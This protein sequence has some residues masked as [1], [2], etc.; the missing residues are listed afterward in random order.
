[1]EAFKRDWFVCQGIG[2]MSEAHFIWEEHRCASVAPFKGP[3]FTNYVALIGVNYIHTREDLLKLPLSKTLNKRIAMAKPGTSFKVFGYC[4]DSDI[5]LRRLTDIEIKDYLDMYYTYDTLR[6]L[7]TH[8]QTFI[9]KKL[10]EEESVFASKFLKLKNKWG[11]TPMV[12]DEV[13]DYW[14]LKSGL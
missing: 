14:K 4:R 13:L 5:W 6:I 11:F 3:Y 9:P 8:M 7:R 1:V 12:L 10:F 2:L